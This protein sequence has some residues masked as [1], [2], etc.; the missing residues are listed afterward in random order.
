MRRGPVSD[1]A[2]ILGS[3]K[4]RETSLIVSALTRA[5]G[6]VK[7]VAKGARRQGRALAHL[8][9]PGNELELVFYPHVD[10]ELW[11]LAD[12]SLRRAALTGARGLDKLSHLLAALELAERLLPE[13]EPLPEIEAVLRRFLDLW[14]EVAPDR[15]LALFFGLEAALA[16]ELGVGLDLDACGS[17]G[18][19]L[20]G[21]VR[22][23]FFA[24]EGRLACERCAG[25]QAQ[26]MDAEE[27]RVLGA[28]AAVLEGGDAP[29]LL[30]PQ[31]RAVGRLL[32]EH[33]SHH[34]TGYRLPRALYWT[35]GSRT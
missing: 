8:L 18:R 7:L 34:L 30:E 23:A 15:S 10:R 4:L 35:G 27:L 16:R 14:H 6:H 20:T 13:R 29:Q 9:E 2:V 5:H 22:A 25:A 32:H 1:E 3:R 24:A 17:C 33:L 26:W 12:A 21:A 19:P 11:I 28:V 31:R